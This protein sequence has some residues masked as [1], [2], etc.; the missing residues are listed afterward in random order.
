M[1]GAEAAAIGAVSTDTRGEFARNWKM[2]I[3]CVAGCG[4]CMA[5]LATYSIGPFVK[6]LGEELGWSR[7]AVQA[8]IVFGQGLSA[9][10]AILA[11]AL[12]DRFGARALAITGLLGT[13]FGFVLAS[14]SNTLG[15]F[16]LAYSL[17]ALLGAGAGFMTWS[18]AITGEFNKNRGL[19]LAIA[20]SGTGISGFLLP[21]LLVWVI[22]GYGWRVGYL[23]LAAIPTLIALPIAF[24]L[25]RPREAAVRAAGRAKAAAAATRGSMRDIF[26]SYRYWVLLFSIICLYLG[27]CGIIPNLIPSLTDDG[28]SPEEAAIAQ[29]AFAGALVCGRLAVGWLVDR[30]WAPAIG[31]IFLTP[32]AIGCLILMSEPTLGGAI[33]AAALVGIAGGAELDLLALLSSRYFGVHNFSRAYAW[34]YAAV[35]IVGGVGPMAFAYLYDITGSY[36]TSFLISACLFAIGGPILLVLGRYPEFP[37][38]KEGALAP[39]HEPAPQH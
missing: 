18:R 34:L 13:G 11:A 2:L 27:I 38:E 19:A 5:G 39:E 4:F 15:F 6:P 9:V 25:F 20:L 33:L 8:S 12:I 1:N 7:T 21:P 28:L 31:A 17:A 35:A 37:D 22:E 14:F 32:P 3:A 30:F 29:S 24:V 23:V 36:D 16:Y 10:G 26:G